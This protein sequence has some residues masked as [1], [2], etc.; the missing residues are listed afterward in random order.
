MIRKLNAWWIMLK[1]VGDTLRMGRQIDQL[2]RYYILETFVEEGLFDYLKEPRTYGQ[3]LAEFNYVDN[4]YTRGLFEVLASDKHNVI[5]K[6]DQVYR[7]NPDESV[8]ELSDIVGGM[9]KRYH[10]FGLMAKGMARYIPPRLRGEP[11][12]LSDTFE[13]DGRQL[14]TKFDKTLG[15]KVYAASRDA[16]FALLTNDERKYLRGKKLLEVGCGSGRE[17]AELWL[18]AGGDIQITAIDPILSLLELA[19]HHFAD[20]LDE[21]EHGHPALTD[22][23]RPVFKPHSATNLPYEDNSFDVVFHAFVLHWTP[24]PQ[25]A[26]SEMIRVLKPGGLVFGLQP[27]KPAANPYFDLVVRINESV[28]GFFW[29]E[30]FRRWYAEQ[31]VMLETMTPITIFRGHKPG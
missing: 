12:E 25:K 9:T 15:S 8:P 6:E 3:I 4:D 11:I 29:V 30:E 26:I 5:I 27:T 13:Q 28:H 19:Q 7:T 24:D 31:G 17:T 21:I 20:Y 1:N 16:A 2:F 23:N 10:N 14:M 22:A 18:K